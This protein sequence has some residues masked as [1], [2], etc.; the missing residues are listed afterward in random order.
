[1]TRRKAFTRSLSLLPLALVLFG[2]TAMAQKTSLEQLVGTWTIVLVDNVLPDG[3]RVHLYGSNPQGIVMFDAGGHYSLQ[4]MSDGRPK[5]AA[6][7]KSKGTPEEYKAAVQG[8]NCHFGRYTVDERD[9]TVTLH[10]EHATFS[11][12]EGTELKLPFTLSGDQSKLIIPHPTTG[13][14]NVTGEVGLKRIRS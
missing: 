10:V 14:P 11:N 9:H 4:I 13:G 5:F 8:S 7:D 3:G 12:W 6:S 1:M 2:G